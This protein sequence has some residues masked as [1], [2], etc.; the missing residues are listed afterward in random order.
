M[1]VV[2]R[3]L[4]AALHG[5]R[6]ALETAAR[7]PHYA[8]VGLI[9]REDLLRAREHC[10]RRFGELQGVDGD[11]YTLMDWEQRLFDR[12]L[13]RDDRI[14]LVGCGTGRDLF[15]L[16]ERGHRAE[17]LD[18]VPALVERA[19]ELLAERGHR[20]PLHAGAIE[21]TELPGVFDAV[22]FSWYCYSYVPGRRTRV[23]TLARIRRH[24]APG[25]RI[26]ISYVRRS[27]DPRRL[28][29]LIARAAGRISGSD[30]RLEPGDTVL[31]PESRMEA[32]HYEHAFTEGEIEQEAI[33]AGLAVVFHDR[34]DE[35]LIV[36]AVP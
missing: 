34:R 6:R 22:I 33:D 30:W 14:L 31:L 25:G 7:A 23:A 5:G 1:G 26:L 2:R 24:L 21:S 10:W 35:G 19:R 32:A 3:A 11:A 12:F 9:R 18:L 28:P 17:G 4:F 27:R 20:P 13:R 15:G 16:L 29:V 36:L 8:A